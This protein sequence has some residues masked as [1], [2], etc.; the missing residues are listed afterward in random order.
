MGRQ[1]RSGKEVRNSSGGEYIT[2]SISGGEYYL[3]LCV[4]VH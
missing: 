1:Q 3:A 4:T 2:V